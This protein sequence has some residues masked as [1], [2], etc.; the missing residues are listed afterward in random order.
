MSPTPRRVA[1]LENSPILGETCACSAGVQA[2]GTF[3]V[4]WLRRFPGLGGRS[5]RLVILN[6]SIPALGVEGHGISRPRGWRSDPFGAAAA[7]VL[8]GA[9]TIPTGRW[10]IDA[11][12]V[13]SCGRC[14]P[15]HKVIIHSCGIGD[16]IGPRKYARIT[17]IEENYQHQV[18]AEDSIQLLYERGDTI[19]AN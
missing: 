6:T 12:T 18:P 15:F 8:H 13:A 11:R 1:V 2:S 9:R 4:S 3:R 10:A 16:W 5:H 19:A 17:Q 14:R 7:G